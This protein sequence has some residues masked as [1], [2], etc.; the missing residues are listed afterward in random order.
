MRYELNFASEP[1]HGFKKIS[2]P[3]AQRQRIKG[4]EF[5]SEIVDLEPLI[6]WLKWHPNNESPSE[7]TR[8]EASTIRKPGVYIVIARL[9]DKRNPTTKRLKILYVGETGRSTLADR[10]NKGGNDTHTKMLRAIGPNLRY[11]FAAIEA[12][13]ACPA[14]GCSQIIE[15]L[16]ARTL[17]RAWVLIPEGQ[18]D[19]D[20]H[21]Y[22]KKPYR[23]V[24]AHG[25]DIIVHNLLPDPLVRY[26]NW[27]YTL[28]NDMSRWSKDPKDQI[29]SPVVRPDERAALHLPD[30]TTWEL[31]SLI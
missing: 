12:S 22:F 10:I 20:D 6:V 25:G 15:H 3:D 27:A 2:N 16:I 21:N 1:F 19:P 31:G 13:N 11:Y 8:G 30:G 14:G 9:V 5:E 29:I 4:M 24:R 28:T 17:L 18:G 7:L 26:L 23:L